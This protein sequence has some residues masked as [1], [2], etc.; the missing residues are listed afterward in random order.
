M[1]LFRGSGNRIFFFRL[2]IA[3][4]AHPDKLYQV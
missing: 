3:D 2:E 4:I 1:L